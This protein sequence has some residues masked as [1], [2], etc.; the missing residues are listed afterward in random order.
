MIK[1]TSCKL[2]DFVE[3]HCDGTHS[4]FHS[5]E[6]IQIL[7]EITQ[8]ARFAHAVR[9]AMLRARTTEYFAAAPAMMPT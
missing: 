9:G 5:F 8:R 6:I 7:D 4:G 2:S 1:R 3:V